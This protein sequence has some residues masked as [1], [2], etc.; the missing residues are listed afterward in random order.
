MTSKN[1]SESMQE[2]LSELERAEQA[3]KALNRLFYRG[4]LS[5]KG[6]ERR[7][8]LLQSVSRLQAEAVA[9]NQAAHDLAAAER[10]LHKMDIQAE[11]GQLTNPGLI[12]QRETLRKLVADL[13]EK[14]EPPQPS[15]R[16]ADLRA[17]RTRQAQGEIDEAL[18]TLRKMEEQSAFTAQDGSSRHAP[19]KTV[20]QAQEELARLQDADTPAKVGTRTQKSLTFKLDIFPGKVSLGYGLVD[21][22]PRCAASAKK[23]PTK[24]VYDR[25]KAVSKVFERLWE[26]MSPIIRRAAVA[27]LLADGESPQSVRPARYAIT[28]RPL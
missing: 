3:L 10:L 6:K 12:S 5:R 25:R 23:H 8:R 19:L 2:A 11:M 22:D 4:K 7:E 27:Q 17:I 21:N 20:A 13:R 26:Q 24:D 14:A 18:G 15:F 16:G 9:R 28:C 1:E